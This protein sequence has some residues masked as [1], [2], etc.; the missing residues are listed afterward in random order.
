MVATTNSA[1]TP[2]RDT[3]HRRSRHERKTP[4]PTGR[5]GGERGAEPHRRPG[6]ES[7]RQERAPRTDGPRRARVEQGDDPEHRRDDDERGER[8]G[9][10][11]GGIHPETG[12]WLGLPA[13]PRGKRPL[14]A[15]AN[16]GAAS[17]PTTTAGAT[18][19]QDPASG[20]AGH[21]QRGAHVLLL[22]D[23]DD[24]AAGGLCDHDEPGQRRDDHGDSQRGDLDADARRDGNIGA[25][26]REEVHVVGV[27]DRPQL[28]GHGIDPIRVGTNRH[29]RNDVRHLLAVGASER[30]GEDEH[31]R[32]VLGEVLL[33]ARHAGHDGIDRRPVV[34]R[35]RLERAVVVGPLGEA[36]RG[37]RSQADDR[38]GPPLHPPD[39]F[40]VDEDPVRFVRRWV[41]AGDD[42]LSRPR[43]G[44]GVDAGEERLGMLGRDLAL[45]LGR[46]PG[47]GRHPLHPGYCGHLG[48]GVARAREVVLHESLEVVAQP[49]LRG[50]VRRAGRVLEPLVSRVG[51]AGSGPQR[52]ADATGQRDQHG[53]REQRGPPPSPLRRHPEAKRAH[54][55]G[56]RSQASP[57]RCHEACQRAPE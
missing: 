12:L 8:A 32:P 11:R 44:A 35:H 37:H 50:E 43:A 49:Q 42:P 21:A 30:L 9:H 1:P 23:R 15:Q 40:L 3:E 4:T 6:E 54:R 17:A 5:A 19:S 45:E 10:E 29:R 41:T 51:P 36:F 46:P 34:R 47:L 31:R 24:L 33:A 2:T 25:L 13:T 55:E 20:V 28:R 52:R 26:G 18:A 22:T 7:A 27:E 16:T 48:H 14:T 53:Q 57:D 39:C 56:I 38:S